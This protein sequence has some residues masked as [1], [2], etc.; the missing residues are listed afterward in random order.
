MR[1]TGIEPDDIFFTS[2]LYACSHS[3]LLNEGWQFFDSMGS[4]CGIEPKLEPYACMVDLLSHS[5]NLPKAYRF[6]KTMPIKPDA[7]IWGALLCGCKIHHDVELA[8]KW[9]SMF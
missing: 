3:G 9:L 1:I 8:E 7:A 6:I 2:I 5:G 4:E